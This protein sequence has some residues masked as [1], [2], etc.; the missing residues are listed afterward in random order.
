MFLNQGKSLSIICGALKW[1]KDHNE[2][3]HTNLEETI[4]NLQLDKEKL[5]SSS[6]DW[7]SSQAKEIELNRKLQEIKVKLTRLNEYD[8]KIEQLQNKVKT[9]KKKVWDAPKKT[10]EVNDANL[11]ENEDDLVLE[12][13]IPGLEEE[14]D[15]ESENE[16]AY[17]PVKVSSKVFLQ[18]KIKILNF[19]HFCIFVFVLI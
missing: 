9:S 3:I 15:E 16:D 8:Q 7:L 12:D 1:L 14:S 17:V 19:E 11:E 13:V 5:Q 6:N 2:L 4:N 18:M 10:V